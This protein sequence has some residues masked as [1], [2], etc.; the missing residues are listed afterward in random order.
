MSMTRRT[1]HLA[2]ERG[3]VAIMFALLI[4][5]LFMLAAI[6]LDIGN[7]YVHKRHL[8]TQVDA[9]VL[10]AGP[11]FVGCYHSPGAA[12][13]AIRQQ[14]LEYAGDLLRA[15][16]TTN[17][18]VQ[19]P[20]DVRIVLNGNRYWQSSDG[21]LSPINGYGLDDTMAAP[22]DPCSTKM[23]DAKA[24]DEDAPPLWG[25]LPLTPS[26][27][28]HA[29]IEIRKL[30]ASSGMLPWAV[31][32][33]DPR[34]LWA[35]F[36]N[37][38]NGAVF[39]QQELISADD[40]NLPWSEWATVVDG[41]NEQVVLDG[42][43]DN[44]SVIILV[45]K[46]DPTPQ[47][48]GTLASI[49]SQSPQLVNCYAGA[50]QTSGASF[51]HGYN[52]GGSGSLANPIV[53]QVELFPAGC[54]PSLDL[55][56]PHFTL[57]DTC[58]ALVQAV[59]DFGVTG[60]T[61]P[62]AMPN[63]VSVTASPGGAMSWSSNVVGGSL[64]T[65]SFNLASGRTVL[66]LNWESTPRNNNCNQT[67]R[68]G[69]F[70]KVAAP[71]MA[72]I[73]SGPIQYLK[74]RASYGN[75][76][77]P[78]PDANSVEKNDPGNPRYDYV[79]TVGLPRPIQVLPATDPPLVLRLSNPSGSQNQAIDCDKNINYE[80][81]IT[82]GCRTK[83]RVNYDD[84][85]GDGDLEWRNIQCLGY[86]TGNLPPDQFLNDPAPDCAM[87]ETGDKTGQMRQG[88]ANRF[89]NP[90]MPNY[91]PAP[92]ASQDDID[93]FFETHDFANDPRY[94][95]L[96]ITDNTAFTGQ[97]NEPVPVKYFAGFYVTG[98]DIGGATNGCGDP[99]GGGPLRGNE[100]HPILGCSYPPS[101]DNG[102]AWGHFV[103]IVIFSSGGDPDDELCAFGRDPGV[104]LPVLVE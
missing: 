91:W 59:I 36:V 41:S 38:D 96:I 83:Y 28:T 55:S 5:V 74:L 65:G 46:E 102:D 10:A 52:G 78:V 33:I 61:N 23:L 62:G 77:L 99:D 8:Q 90:C 80:Q 35:L 51:I 2:S 68:S 30:E 27:K 37:E 11:A 29:K 101:R 14:A 16:S 4:P 95:T 66:N 81:E 17:Q 32:E 86:F 47:V 18:Q 26:P 12:N 53:R 79:V 84:L 100:C 44:T 20:G 39:D 85:D 50:T 49:C 15:P 24:T 64:F 31:P 57:S 6:V 92:T 67:I 58:T 72:N 22:G 104:C 1:S 56:A 97:G 89:E 82:D 94:V 88:L 48:T 71:Y 34:S 103:N 42:S 73:A 9:A 63:C 19:E 75:S 69:G 43:H 93:D 25:L 76:G 98:W 87:T 21:T 7:W 13:V 54:D 70:T 3:Q 60:N 45:S 40:P